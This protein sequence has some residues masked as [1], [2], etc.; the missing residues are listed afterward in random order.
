VKSDRIRQ[1]PVC[2]L[3]APSYE[4]TERV[5]WTSDEINAFLDAMKGD[6]HAPLYTFAIATG[7]RQGELLGLKWSD[8]DTAGGVVRV[9]RQWTR[10]G[11]FGD[12]KSAAGRRVV[13]LG[14]LGR[15]ALA[16]QEGQQKRDKM[17]S[18]GRWANRDDLIF[19]DRLAAALHHRTVWSSFE[20]RV[21]RAGVRR[22]RFHDL[23][24][25]FAT[26]LFDEGEEL[27]SIA[28]ALGHTSVDTTKRVYAHLLP[29]RALVT[30]SR[31]DAALGRRIEEIAQ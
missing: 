7:L 18:G 12:V 15:W 3:P 2:K 20:V 22:I 31:I 14:E 13:G 16:A 1:N 28:A 9:V 26:I 29:K 27:G 23:R 17:S 10:G 6:R 25:A 8:V 21:A 4:R 30:A 19:T 24:H 5:T 11:T